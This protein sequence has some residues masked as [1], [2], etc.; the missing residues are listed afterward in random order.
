MN[1]WPMVL[2][3]LRALRWIAWL[4]PLLIAIAVAGGVA[5]SAPERALRSAS[6]RA[7]DDFDLL[8]G[9]PGSQA[10]LVLTAIYLEPEALPTARSSTGSPLRVASATRPPSPSAM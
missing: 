10:Q 4:I 3:D 5:V 9:A 2:A 6:A 7:A 1:P 8:I